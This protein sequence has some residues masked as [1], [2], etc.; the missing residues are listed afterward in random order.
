M[1]DYDKISREVKEGLISASTSFRNDK[2]EALLI[3]CKKE[4]NKTAQSIIRMLI[5]NYEIANNNRCPLCDDTG[6]PHIILELGTKS[7]ISSDHIDAIYDG[8]RRGL[9]DLPGRSMA[10]LGNDLQRLDQSAGLSNDPANVESAPIMFL[11]GSGEKSQ[12]HILMLGGG[13][14]IRA[15]TFR[16][17][18]H[19]DVETV[20]N[21]IVSW[22]KEVVADLGCTPCTLAVGVGRSHYEATSMML[23]A[24]SK[25]NYL[26]QNSIESE[27]TRR[28]NESQVGPLGVGGNSTVLATFMRIG[29]QRAS[30][31][32]IACVRPCCCFE[33]RAATVEMDLI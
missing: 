13:P 31:V 12:I 30:G 15:K 32:R 8:I 10:V 9:K 18:H 2:K 5:D 28:V 23:M 33:P 3:A 1:T 26:I 6:I 14:A 7:S 22:S 4:N 16:I 21:E 17:F 29:P 25:G 27:I 20:I 19:H 24:Q 11:K